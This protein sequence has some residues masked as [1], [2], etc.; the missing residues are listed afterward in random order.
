[1]GCLSI[2]LVKLFALN[3][4]PEEQTSF[5]IGQIVVDCCDM[6]CVFL[7]SYFT[8]D[9]A[10]SSAI[11]AHAEAKTCHDFKFISFLDKKK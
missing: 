3:C 7:G 6:Y 5:T 9:G 2:M 4:C 8:S 1:M 11:A 10:P